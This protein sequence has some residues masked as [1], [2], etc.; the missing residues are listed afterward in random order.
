MFFQGNIY[1]A[2][3]NI[4]IS[5][6]VTWPC[7]NRFFTGWKSTRSGSTSFSF[8]ACPRFNAHFTVQYRYF[9]GSHMTLLKPFFI[10]WKSTRSGSTSFSFDTCPHFDARFDL[11]FDSIIL[12]THVLSVNYQWRHVRLPWYKPVTPCLPGMYRMNTLSNNQY[13]LGLRPRVYWLL[14]RVHP[15]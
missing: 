6:E 13:S 7:L 11:G 1:I 12:Q 4:D 3:C 10:G 5:P 8:N 9:P 14:L 2:Q 15:W